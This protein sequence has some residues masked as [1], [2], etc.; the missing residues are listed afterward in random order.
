MC[1]HLLC[2]STDCFIVHRVVLF[3]ASTSVTSFLLGQF[4]C[5]PRNRER[6]TIVVA[7]CQS[8]RRAHA[9]HT[10][11]QND[12]QGHSIVGFAP[13]RLPRGQPKCCFSFPG[14]PSGTPLLAYRAGTAT[15]PKRSSSR[16]LRATETVIAS[17]RPA[18]RPRM[19]ILSNN[20]EALGTPPSTHTRHTAA[21]E[22][23]I[24]YSI[25]PEAV[26]S[27]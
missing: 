23:I 11:L 18:G 17:H 22:V 27:R 19:M 12:P 25:Q 26:L 16:P 21:I 5:R 4:P 13:R 6:M 20:T 9:L 15:R 10:L 2:L 1:I 7:L 8:S 14:G 24:I 3:T